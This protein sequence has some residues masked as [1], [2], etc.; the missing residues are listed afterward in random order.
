MAAPLADLF[1]L[2]SWGG[3]TDEFG[4]SSL[5]QTGVD[6][7][8]V[9]NVLNTGALTA[10]TPYS[11]GGTGGQGYQVDYLK[12]PKVAGTNT[13]AAGWVPWANSTN[14]LIDPSLLRNDPNYGWI[15]P[16]ADIKSDHDP[17]TQ[18][19]NMLPALLG[20]IFGGAILGPGMGAIGSTIFKQL[21]NVL[22]SKGG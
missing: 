5:A 4:N 13:S 16:G 20:T 3:G 18:F 12:L 22:F 10:T 8:G 6:A 1:T 14:K 7:A 15:V 11:G 19:G 9:Q 2:A 17:L 21:E